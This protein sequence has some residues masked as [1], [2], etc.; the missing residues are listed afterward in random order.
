MPRSIFHI[1]YIAICIL[2]ILASS[3]CIGGTK[4]KGRE[5]PIA[6]KPKVILEDPA[7]FVLMEDELPPGF[8]LDLSW[9]QDLEEV[10]S[11]WDD[12]EEGRE[13]LIEW[14]YIDSYIVRFR[15]DVS[16]LDVFTEPFIIMSKVTRYE[17]ASGAANAL[18]H[19]FHDLIEEEGHELLSSVDIGGG[20]V[21]LKYDYRIEDSDFTHY[22]LMFRY[23][24]T[25]GSVLVGGFVGSPDRDEIVGYAIAME[26]KLE[27]A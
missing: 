2:L 11:T 5:S 20:G 15:R 13:K 1:T 26:E 9:Y 25:I 24:N 22:I 12:P 23:G 18:D 17:D 10:A 4:P 21:L 14:G 7:K 27:R 6:Q 8:H 3:G 19:K 16:S